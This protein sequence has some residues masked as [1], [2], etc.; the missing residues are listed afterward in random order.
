MQTDT[1]FAPN[2]VLK[3]VGE[4]VTVDFT[5]KSVERAP[6]GGVY[7]TATQPDAQE[8]R[9]VLSEETFDDMKARG[10]SRAELLVGAEVRVKGPLVMADHYT[11]LQVASIK[12][13]TRLQPQLRPAGGP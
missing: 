2:E 11:V 7:L 4:R 9:V 8:F 12:Q 1:V 10:Y 13:F 3:R 6:G 5:V